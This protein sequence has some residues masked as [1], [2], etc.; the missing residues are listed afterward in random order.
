[1]LELL[2]LPIQ[3]ART[4]STPRAAAGMDTD[5]SEN[6][7][8]QLAERDGGAYSPFKQPGRAVRPPTS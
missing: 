7:P 1:M 8:K 2:L 5:F 3:E 4:S 6:A